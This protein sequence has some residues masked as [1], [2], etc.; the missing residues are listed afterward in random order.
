MKN[1]KLSIEK[2]L[3]HQG[4]CDASGAIALDDQHFVVANDEDNILRIYDSTTSGKPVSWGTHSDAGIDI[5][6]YFQNVI[7][8]K[9]ADIEGAAQLDGVIYWI[10]S[11]GR[12]SEGELRPK[13][14][15][16]FGNIISADEGGK[17]IKKVGVSYTQLIEDVLQDERLKYYGF[18]AAE[19]LPPKAKGGL[20]IEGLA[21]TPSGSSGSR[22]V[23]V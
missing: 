16:F 23:I 10:T 5:N 12:N 15:Q 1:I 20:N 13:R 2:E 9:E 8:K 22:V 14:H 4:I 6:G 3:Q 21:A 11:H 18:E 7:N 19:K 17:S